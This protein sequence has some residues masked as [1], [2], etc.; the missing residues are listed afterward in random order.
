VVLH[1]AVPIVVNSQNLRSS[2]AAVVS[3]SYFVSCLKIVPPE[4][5]RLHEVHPARAPLAALL[6]GDRFGVGDDSPRRATAGLNGGKHLAHRPVHNYVNIA[7]GRGAQSPGLRF[8]RFA[9]PLQYAPNP[10]SALEQ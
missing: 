9:A 5:F 4:P 2:Y 8:S 7:F 1:R 6:G 3:A 10:A